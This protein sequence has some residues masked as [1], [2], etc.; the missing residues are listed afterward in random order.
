[1]RLQ[2]L[3][4][5]LLV[6]DFNI[7]RFHYWALPMRNYIHLVILSSCVLVTGGRK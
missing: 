3:L 7:L 5:N 6:L 1:M 2:L 4:Y